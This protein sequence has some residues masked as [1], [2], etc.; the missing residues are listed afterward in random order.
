M[1]E[2]FQSV[3]RSFAIAQDDRVGAVY[4]VFRIRIS[5][6]SDTGHWESFLVYDRFS[7]GFDVPK[8]SGRG[9]QNFI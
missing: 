8:S 7:H 1:G 6:S 2:A 4:T 9:C 3:P 5:A